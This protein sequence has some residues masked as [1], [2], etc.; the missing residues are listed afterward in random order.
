[1]HSL[2]LSGRTS[3]AGG[4]AEAPGLTR[5]GRRARNLWRWLN[6]LSAVALLACLILLAR[7]LPVE[8]AVQ[9]LQDAVEGMGVFGP[10]IFGGAYV[11]AGLLFVPGAA[12]TIA[13]GALFGLL[14]GTAVVSVA[15]TIT[16]AL[17]F[18]AARYLARRSVER[19]A[20]ARPSFAAVDRAIGKGGWK[21][22]ALL[23]LSPAVPFSVGNYLYGLTP[24]RFWP[25]VLASWIFMLPGTFLY[26]YVGHLGAT[27]LAVAGGGSN[28]VGYGK[29]ALLLAGLAATVVV[30]V[31]V[32][33]L[34]RRALAEQGALAPAGPEEGRSEGTAEGGVGLRG[35][36]LP[37]AALLMIAATAA[38]WA[39][40]DALRSLFGPPRAVLEEAYLGDGQG[41]VFDHSRLDA[42]LR[43]HVSE[44]GW[45]DYAGLRSDA[46]ELD[47]YLASVEKAPFDELG[48]DEKLALLLNAYNAFTLRLILDYSEG[49]RLRSIKD[50]P[51]AKR[52]E[53]RRWK[54]GGNTWSLNQIEHEQI[55][56]KFRE[57]R[58]H[59]A[60]VC[61]AIG[62][63]P[64]RSE[65]Y[66]GAKIEQQL[67]EQTRYVH[68]HE[69]WFRFDPESGVV[70]L[71]RLYDWYGDDFK[72][73]AGSVL[74]YAAQH[75]EALRRALESG[76]KIRIDWLDYDWRLNAVENRP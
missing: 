25:Y 61:A 74:Q 31:Y 69:R 46:A 40:Q 41:A 75:S 24:I 5:P 76:R 50:I 45:V 19:A 44:G 52:W 10:A 1:M 64:L 60:L 20:Q 17:A 55:R 66:T 6:L 12:L 51:D 35:L 70:R 30:T 72:Q 9:V 32:T 15:S 73:V 22:V 39:R 58:V 47:A 33:R 43:K 8:R 11:L 63:P 3:D 59:F 21:I 29:T 2:E 34:A 26:V 4:I 14:W 65:A 56:P 23:R 36:V 7:V 28:A 48:R 71:T 68:T 37:G 54:V 13:A 57:P 42:L 38:A 49:G 18:L 16:A 62:C 27:G 53:D 67:A